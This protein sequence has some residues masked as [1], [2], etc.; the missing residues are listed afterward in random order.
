MSP[1]PAIVV[2]VCTH[3]RAQLLG[4]C[5]RSLAGQTLPAERFEVIVVDSAAGT[6]GAPAPDVPTGVRLIAATQPGLS[7]ARN[8]GLAAAR[9]ELAAFIDD[10]ATAEPG[11][12]A[13]ILAAFEADPQAAAV[14]GP[15]RPIWPGTRP[16]WLDH[17]LE[18]FFSIIDR[19]PVARRLDA[20]EWLAGTNIAFR[21]DIA[22]RSGGFNEALG[23]QPGSLL[24]NEEL[25]LT[26]ALRRTGHAVRYEPAALV[27]HTVHADRL[28]Q[29][30]LRRRATWQA[31]SDLL[32][33]TPPAPE[34]VDM[35]GLWQRVAACLGPQPAQYR[36]LVGL[37]RDLEDAAGCHAQ[38]EAIGALVALLANSGRSLETA[39]LGGRPP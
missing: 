32:S 18:G 14:G 39:L 2:I 31:I 6:P 38:T 30:W 3:A 20:D 17:R 8:I 16:A 27:H 7:H 35:P 1:T 15:V 37:T 9:A 21:R 36:N 22:L 13:A 25:A 5:L 23:R 12:L 28:N 29:A 26:E 24:G 33:D 19:G 11:W 4:V 34:A 10:D